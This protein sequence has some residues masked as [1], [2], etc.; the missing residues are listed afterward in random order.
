MTHPPIA[1]QPILDT[2]ITVIDLETIGLVAGGDRVDQVAVARID[3]MP[4]GSPPHLLLVG[5]S[6]ISHRL[7][8]YNWSGA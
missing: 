4:T 5:G 1:D 8:D 7:P 3:P 6:G 2:P